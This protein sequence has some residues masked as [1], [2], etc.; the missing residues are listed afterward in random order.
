MSYARRVNPS[1]CAI[2]FASVPPHTAHIVA[3]HLINITLGVPRRHTAVCT[4]TS[5][6]GRM[7]SIGIYNPNYSKWRGDMCNAKDTCEQKSSQEENS[8]QC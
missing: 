2:S 1:S 6:L 3:P 5:G 8:R 4:A 7:D